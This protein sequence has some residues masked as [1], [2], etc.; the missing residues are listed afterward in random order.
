LLSGVVQGS[1]IGAL[2]FLV[3]LFDNE[4]AEKLDRV[5][6]KVKLLAYDVI[7]KVYV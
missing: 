1:G 2:M 6:V 7:V 4:L 5:G 3:G